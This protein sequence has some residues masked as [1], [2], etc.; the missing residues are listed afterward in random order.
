MS[1]TV[2]SIVIGELETI[3]KGLVMGLEKLEI[4]RRAESIQ[5]AVLLRSAR[6]LKR[7]LETWGDLLSFKLQWKTIC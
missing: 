4:G 3:P 6:V 2:I 7:V 5:T 1:V